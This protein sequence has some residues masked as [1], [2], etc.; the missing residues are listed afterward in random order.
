MD[1][2]FENEGMGEESYLKRFKSLFTGARIRRATL[3]AFTV[4]IAQQM[5]GSRWPAL[6]CHVPW[7]Y[8]LIQ[9]SQ[10]HRLLFV[11]RFC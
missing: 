2:Q 9:A 4:M 11:D 7:R 3:A 8:R 1:A 6:R 5:C 10:C